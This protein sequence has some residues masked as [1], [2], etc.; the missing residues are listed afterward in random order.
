MLKLLLLHIAVCVLF[1]SGPKNTNHKPLWRHHLLTFHGCQNML[2]F[3]FKLAIVLLLYY[4]YFTFCIRQILLTSSRGCFCVP[5]HG[6]HVK[7]RK[8]VSG[9]CL[10]VAEMNVSKC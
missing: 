4:V 10:C 3:L 9:V 6:H 7:L 5:M 1:Y 2:D 8:E